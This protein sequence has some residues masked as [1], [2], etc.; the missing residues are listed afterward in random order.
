MGAAADFLAE[1]VGG[2]ADI[3]PLGAGQ[4][5][6]ADRLVVG[7]EAKIVDMNQA[8]LACD[9]DAFASQ[10]VEGHAAYFGGGNHRGRLHLIANELGGGGVEF[11][12][13]ERRH[14]Q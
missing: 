12:E 1:F 9:L 7:A 4:P 3:S 8:R 13:R 10:L 11:F 14:G 2:G 6:M 5:E